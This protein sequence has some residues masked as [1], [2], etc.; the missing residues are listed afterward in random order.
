MAKSLEVYK[1]HRLV[2]IRFTRAVSGIPRWNS[3]DLDDRGYVKEQGGRTVR[4]APAFGPVVGIRQG[5]KVRIKI[6]REWIE[7][8]ANL[9]VTSADD[10]IVRVVSPAADTPVATPSNIIE[11]EGVSGA[12]YGTPSKVEV[13]YD[14]G[15]APRKV[16]AELGVQVYTLLTINLRV[17]RTSIRGTRQGWNDATIR[18]RINGMNRIW[19]PAGIRCRIREIRNDANLNLTTAGTITDAGVTGELAQV[20]GQGRGAPTRRLH[21][22]LVGRLFDPSPGEGDYYGLGLDRNFVASNA[23]SHTGICL[24]TNRPAGSGTDQIFENDL[25]HELG[26]ILGLWHP[27]RREGNRAKEDIWSRRQLMHNW[28]PDNTAPGFRRNV[29]YGRDQRGAMICIKDLRNVR[30]DRNVYTSRRTVRL[31]RVY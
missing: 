22:Y 10:S 16:I 27:E 23:G 3:V 15:T 1:W 12:T 31:G 7:D 28:N 18:A 2:P 14:T 11:L 9:Y 5:K 19:R 29:S 30:A 26:H 20:M 21:I 24:A 6:I 13:S 4:E 25:A 17:H 8:A